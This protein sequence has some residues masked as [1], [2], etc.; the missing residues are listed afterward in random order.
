MTY[1]DF[2]AVPQHQLKIHARLE[3][4]G[5]WC[6]GS[7]HAQV[8]P[9]FRLYRSSQARTAYIETS[10]PVDTE[11]AARIAKAVAVVE[12]DNRQALSWYYINRGSPKRACQV[13]GCTQVALATLVVDGRQMLMDSGT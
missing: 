6:Y 11:D 8:S 4:W 12:Q 3:N 2:S 10:V 13:I 5:R 9:M 1:A 7:G